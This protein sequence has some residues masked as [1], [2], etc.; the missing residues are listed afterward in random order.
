MILFSI[1]LFFVFLCTTTS[2]PVR[3]KVNLA[4][5]YESR[6]TD[7]KHFFLN[8][9]SPTLNKLKSYIDLELIP[10]G[11]ENVT[12]VGNTYYY[13]CQHGPS[14][15]WGNR[16]EA[17]V[18]QQNTVH[19]AYEYSKCIFNQ[20]DF[21][22]IVAHAKQCAQKLNL[23]WDLIMSCVNGPQSD[24]LM[25][26]FWKQTDNLQPKHTFI[27]WITVNGQGSANIQKQSLSNLFKFLC[28]NYLLGVPECGNGLNGS[29][30]QYSPH[31]Y[32]YN[33]HKSGYSNSYPF[34]T[35][36]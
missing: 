23:N 10:F 8:Q 20:A 18:L 26:R 4:V 29:K 28:S 19:F 30:K 15:C 6:C 35:F 27:P 32:N 9:L 5:Y 16:I 21:K 1:F 36:G 24:V 31:Y 22:N 2:L 17:C 3:E 7:S 34:K 33:R 11:N 14:E 25:E 12:K 13:S